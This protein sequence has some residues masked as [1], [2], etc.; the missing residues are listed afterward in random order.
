FVVK[1]ATHANIMVVRSSGTENVKFKYVVF[2]GEM[3]IDQYKQGSG[4]LVGQANAAGAMAIGAVLYLN[5]PVFSGNPPTIASFSSRGGVA[6]NGVVRNKPDFTAPNG[7]NTS[8]EFGSNDI[9]HDFIPN[10]FGTSCSAPHAAGVA[11]LMIEARK[12]YWNEV[13]SPDSVRLLLQNTAIDM[14]NNGF[15]YISGYGFIQADKAIETFAMPKPVGYS[16]HTV[17]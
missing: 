2:R 4:T 10:F 15:D 7:V 9:D 8:V 11:A 17:D 6:V 13:L 14:D 5:T 12:K 16:L 3:T 1:S